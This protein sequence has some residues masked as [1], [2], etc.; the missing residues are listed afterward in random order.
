MRLLRF[1]RNDEILW[2]NQTYQIGL[3]KTDYVP[4]HCCYC[5]LDSA[6]PGYVDYGYNHGAVLRVDIQACRFVYFYRALDDL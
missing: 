4:R 2:I 5:H 6:V 1:T 3:L